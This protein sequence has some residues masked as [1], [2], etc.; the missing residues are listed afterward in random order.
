MIQERLIEFISKCLWRDVDNVCFV[1][2]YLHFGFAIFEIRS[3]EFYLFNFAELLTSA[4][5]KIVSEIDEILSI[6]I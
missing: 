5:L 3:F 1:K 6:E 4:R 2:R